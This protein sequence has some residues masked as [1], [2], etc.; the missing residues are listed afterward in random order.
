MTKCKLC[1]EIK[2]TEDFYKS[3]PTR[4]KSCRSAHQ[5]TLY[6]ANKTRY[7]TTANKHNVIKRGGDVSDVYDV[8]AVEQFYK[9]ARRLSKKTGIPYEV[10]HIIPLARGGL[11]CQTNLQ[12]ITREDNILKADS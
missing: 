7:I 1:G 10:D 12:V 9:E 5:K 2:S 3:S 4:C 11:H 6:N 8:D